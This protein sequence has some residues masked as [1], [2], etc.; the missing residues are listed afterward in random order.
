MFHEKYVKVR[1]QR[2]SAKLPHCQRDLTS[3]VGGVVNNVQH[4]VHQ[5]DLRSAKGNRFR[6]AFMGHSIYELALLH[7]DFHPLRLHRIHVRKGIGAEEG[8]TLVYQL[9]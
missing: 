1:C 5:F 9:R 3:M 6:Q 2:L 7:L 8:V 4:Q